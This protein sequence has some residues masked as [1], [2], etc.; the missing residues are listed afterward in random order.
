MNE[1]AELGKFTIVP[2]YSTPPTNMSYTNWTIMS[3]HQGSDVVADWLTDT[4][5]RR[6]NGVKVPFH[7]LDVGLVLLTTTGDKAVAFVDRLFHFTSPL[8][9]WLWWAWITTLFLTAVVMWALERVQWL[10]NTETQGSYK[11]G[12]KLPAFLFTRVYQ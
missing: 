11:S 12:V 1:V 10:A 4:T 2:K 9:G 6:L 8:S 5:Q 7:L 3:L